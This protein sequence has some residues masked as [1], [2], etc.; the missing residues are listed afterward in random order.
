[1]FT[2]INKML[3]TF[4]GAAKDAY[5]NLV[6]LLLSTTSTNGAQNNTFL[7][8]SSNNFT[9]TRNGNT[10]QGTFTPFSLPNGWWSTYFT[11]GSTFTAPS[12]SVFNPGAGDFC[13]E[14]FMYRTSG[15]ATAGVFNMYQTASGTGMVVAFDA[16]DKLTFRIG[17]DGSV[18]NFDGVASSNAVPINQWVHVAAARSGNTMAAWVNGTRVGTN[19]TTKTISQT[20]PYIGR[21]YT[22][23]TSH[24]FIGYLSNLRYVVGSPVYDV[25]QTTISVPT[26]PLT[27]ISNTKLLC[28]QS[29][30]F[31]D[32]GTA[33]S[34]SGFPLSVATGTP[35][36][37]NFSPFAPQSPYSVVLNGGSGYFD[38]NGDWL[39]VPANAAFNF[40]N[41][42]FTVE[43]YAYLTSLAAATRIIAQTP[44]GGAQSNSGLLIEVSTAGNVSAFVSNG[45]AFIQTSP[46]N[47]RVSGNTFNH[48]ATVRD[49]NTLRVYVNGVQGGTANLTGVT[50]PSSTEPFTIGRNGTNATNYV[51]GY[52]SGIR[53][54]KDQALVT[55][56]S[57]F[58]PPS[59]PVTASSVGWSG[60]ANVAT[61]I[62]GTVSLITNFTNAGIYDSSQKNDIETIGN[63]SVSTAQSKFGGSS[64]Y[65]DGVGDSLTFK[66]TID[67]QFGS[68]SFTIEG[69]VYTSNVAATQVVIERR[70]ALQ[71]RGIAIFFDTSKLN[72]CAGDTSTTA[73]EIALVSGTLSSNTWYSFSFTRSGTTWRAFVDGNQVG[74]STTWSGTIADETSPWIMGLSFSGAQG[75]I[76][77]LD[78]VRITKGLARY[79]ANYTPTTSNFALQ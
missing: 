10:T 61:S 79:T 1:M 52:L 34:G 45:T 55:G 4:G 13:I 18:S 22:N 65:F 2:A 64:I 48:I 6:T 46:N 43:C 76:G 69:F 75:L 51:N 12:S 16:T 32:N 57:S 24:P 63:A 47:V 44:S 33:N 41:V 3:Q 66:S 20:Q 14:F 50:V 19:S 21:W 77:Y 40:S 78:E 36:V 35:S 56:G 58:T 71:A 72:F 42:N 62:T 5:F 53:V 68:G 59:A 11:S 70:A 8:S 9:I 38:G 23:T 25:S 28:M 74:A 49:G 67:T 30:R 15:S 60:D 73:W 54:I 39:T 31:I 17:N 7:D 26:S 27:N 37:Q 29:N